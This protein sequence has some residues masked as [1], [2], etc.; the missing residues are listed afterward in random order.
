MTVGRYRAFALLCAL[1][2]V[3]PSQ[4]NPHDAQPERPTVATHAGTVARGWL[5]IETGVEADRIDRATSLAVPTTVKIGLAPRLQL[6]LVG[7]IVNATSSPSA[8][9]AAVGL[10]WRL[11]DSLPIVGAFAILPA[12]QLPL[13]SVDRGSGTTEASLLIISSRHFGD[14]EM[15]LNAGYSR[16]IDNSSTAPRTTSV[17][18]ASFGGPL[19]RAFGWVGE[20]YGYPG[21][22]GFSGSSPIVAILAGP[23]YTEKPWL[24]F[25]AGVIVPIGG[26]QPHAVYAGATYN[27]GRIF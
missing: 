21:T 5:E 24:V 20:I 26:P 14:I 4:Q 15:D 3:A 18:S 9:D 19:W 1:A 7:S 6:S 25:D 8:I 17:W 27:V 10:K 11:T 12:I 22:G 16:R 13:G 23:T 2:R